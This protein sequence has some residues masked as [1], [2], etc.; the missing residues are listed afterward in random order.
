MH[1][2]KLFFTNIQDFHEEYAREAFRKFDVDGSGT[3]STDDF[4]KI[5][6]TIRTHLLTEEVK[7]NLKEVSV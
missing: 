4:Y 3:I 2:G 7:N 1:N 6:T 5:M